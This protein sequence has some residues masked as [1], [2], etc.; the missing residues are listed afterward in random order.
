M[1]IK[2]KW[3]VFLIKGKLLIFSNSEDSI[4]KYGEPEFTGTF[5]AC[6]NYVRTNRV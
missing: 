1:P 5:P 2:H 6:R 4:N 3:G